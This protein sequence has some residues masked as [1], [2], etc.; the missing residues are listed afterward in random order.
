MNF[1]QLPTRPCDPAMKI[2]RRMNPASLQEAW[3]KCPRGDHLLW[4]VQ[5]IGI[6]RKLMVLA[7]CDCADQALVLLPESEVRPKKAIDVVRAWCAFQ[8]TLQEVRQAH[9]A[10]SDAKEELPIGIDCVAEATTFLTL[11]I[12]DPAID[13]IYSSVADAVADAFDSLSAQQASHQKSAD[14]VRARIPWPM[15]EEAAKKLGVI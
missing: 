4:F 5:Q 2:L 8:S 6:D 7:A 1:N 11:S 3:E 9:I 13:A 15:I 12:L 10:S 14:L